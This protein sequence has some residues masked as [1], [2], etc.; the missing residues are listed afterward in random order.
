MRKKNTLK[1]GNIRYIIFYD[2]NEKAWFGVGLEFNLVVEG[3]DKVEVMA[4]LFDALHGY[5]EAARKIKIR[6]SVLN[7]KADNEYEE[8]WT[9]LSEET[10]EYQ[11]HLPKREISSFGFFSLS[12]PAHINA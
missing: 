7:Q 4:S 1:K 9:K 2:K 3:D 11:L 8:L 5:V 6:D 12:Q 10:S